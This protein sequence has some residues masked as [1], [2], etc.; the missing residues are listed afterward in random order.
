MNVLSYV[1]KYCTTLAD[2]LCLKNRYVYA[3]EYYSVI[4]REQQWVTCRDMNGL[5]VC[6]T[7]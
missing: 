5:S 2:D 6:H 4:K 1:V 3:M 7:E